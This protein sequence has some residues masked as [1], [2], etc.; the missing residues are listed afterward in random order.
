M[1]QR[2]K[3]CSAVVLAFGSLLTLAAQAQ[4]AATPDT[5]RVEITG[6]AIKRINVEGA[7]PIQTLTAED[8]KKTGATSVTDLIQN[9]SSMQGFTTASQSVN[10]GGGGVTTASLHDMGEKYTLVLLNGHRMASYGTGSAVDLNTIP[11]AAVERVDV[12]LDGASALYGA[13]AIAGV[14]NFILKKDT[15]AGQITASM[16]IPQKSG[17][18]SATASISKGFGDI[19]KNGFNIFLAASFDKQQELNASDRSFSKSGVLKFKDGY[20]NQE[21]D[22]VSNNS[23]PA[24]ATVKLSNG[25]TIYINPGKLTTGACAANT[26]ASGDRCLFDYPATVETIPKA[27][28]ASFLASGRVKIN[29]KTSV[30][31]DLTFSNYTMDSRYAP[32]AQPF[33]ISSAL[34]TKD[35]DPLLAGLGYDSSVTALSGSMGVRLIDAGGRMDR[36]ETN[37]LHTVLG[38][39][40]TLGDWESSV[41]L[42]H[43]QNHRYDKAEGGYASTN[44]IEALIADGSFDPLT[45]QPG[46]ASALLASAV[47]HQTLD[48]TRS[49]LDVAS[50]HTSTTFSQLHLP[51]G[52]VGFATGIDLT[53]QKYVDRPSAIA[54]GAN[55]LQPDYTDSVFGGSSGALPFDSSRTSWGLYGELSVPVLKNLDLGASARFDSYGDVKNKDGFATDGSFIGE[56]TQGKKSSS[57]TFKLSAAF[58]PVKELLLRGSFGTGFKMPTIGDI[59]SPLQAFGNTGMHS[60]PVGLSAE[61]AAYCQSVAYEY[62]IQAGGNPAG[63]STALKPEKSTQWTLGFRVEP[64]PAFSLGA[65]LWTVRLRDQINTVT[66]DT[67]FSDGAKYDSLFTI[68]NDPINGQPTLTFLEVPINTGNAYYQGVDLDGES[69]LSTPVGKITTRAHMTWMLRADY[70][71]PGNDGYVNSMSKVGV[72]GQVTFRYQL[73]AAVTLQRGAFEYTTGFNFKPG[74]KDD[75]TDYCYNS[76]TG[77]DGD[78]NCTADSP[79]RRVSSYTTFDFQTKYDVTKALSV[80][81]GIKNVF[82]RNPPF[83]LNDQSG[84]G[85]ARGF[86]GRYTNPLGRTFYLTGAYSF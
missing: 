10:G 55:S 74:Y 20:G 15:T 33:S 31:G 45:S 67:A 29:D 70:Q 1:F 65:D 41:S 58:R 47:L 51:G 61:K 12:V 16:D 9:L 73:N 46:A 3:I 84:T 72:D 49:L 19:D 25:D 59:S 7:L 71:T 26:V 24:N 81:G 37:T 66:E 57:T 85:N 80:T 8:I 48:E 27:K 30:F 42:T 75:T 6:S 77:Y 43:S 63:D 52:D 2:T 18:K 4:D 38:T 36:Y 50:A 13:D 79:N 35:I 60:C 21:V 64:S 17:G 69:H 86:D 23:V 22:L 34:L 82:D 56:T 11:L 53:R 32:V 14:I 5:Q 39:D 78:L 54:Q 62:N 40:F 68:A 28:R 44:A 76:P 83:S